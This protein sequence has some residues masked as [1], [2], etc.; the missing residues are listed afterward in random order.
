MTAV[1]GQRQQVSLKF[2][3]FFI[4]VLRQRASATLGLFYT[5]S[6]LI[7][8]HEVVNMV[9]EKFL[10]RRR[11]VAKTTATMAEDKSAGQKTEYVWTNLN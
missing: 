2:C 11:L 4:E 5:L 8:I 6:D 3:G 7:V 9:T 10:A 1:R